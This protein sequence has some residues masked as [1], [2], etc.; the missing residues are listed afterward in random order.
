MATEKSVTVT[1]WLDRFMDLEAHLARGG[2]LL[3]LPIDA[4]DSVPPDMVRS[5]VKQMGRERLNQIGRVRDPRAGQTL[6][7]E[8]AGAVQDD[9]SQ[10]LH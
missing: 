7:E 10:E 8:Q 2:S 3:D 6:S 5:L 9:K 1:E 4:L